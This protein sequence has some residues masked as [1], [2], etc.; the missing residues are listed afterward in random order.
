MIFLWCQ[1]TPWNGIFYKEIN[2]CPGIPKNGEERSATGSGNL[3]GRAEKIRIL[4]AKTSKQIDAKYIAE[5]NTQIE[6]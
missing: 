2:T 4:G 3:I 1:I 5:N 6:E